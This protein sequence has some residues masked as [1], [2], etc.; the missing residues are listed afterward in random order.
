MKETR[1]TEVK[2]VELCGGWPENIA[3]EEMEEKGGGS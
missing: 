3:S 2:M 1:K